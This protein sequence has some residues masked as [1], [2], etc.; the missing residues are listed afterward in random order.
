[1]I[2]YQLCPT[3]YII[4]FNLLYNSLS[5]TTVGKQEASYLLS[6]GDNCCS[7]SS[8][9]LFHL[10]LKYCYILVLN[11]SHDSRNIFVTYLSLINKN[12]PGFRQK[13]KKNYYQLS[14][15]QLRKLLLF[16]PFCIVES[17]E[18]YRI[19]MVTQEWCLPQACF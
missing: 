6:H 18:P 10:L 3:L 2:K 19:Q 15:C 4:L 17:T 11:P 14:I 12:S 9:I 16:F 5:N 1:M 7:K 8:Q 13:G